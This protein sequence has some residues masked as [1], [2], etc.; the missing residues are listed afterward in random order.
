V[1][2][3]TRT[4]SWASLACVGASRYEVSNRAEGWYGVRNVQTGELNRAHVSGTSPYPKI[5][6]VCDDGRPRTFDIHVLVMAAHDRPRPVGRDGRPAEIL[7]GPRGP[8]RAWYPEDVRYGSTE[9]NLR[10]RWGR[11]RRWSRTVRAARRAWAGSR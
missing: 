2:T 3:R 10:D 1:R 9:E 11:F 5:T 7:H 6:L 8:L 4:E